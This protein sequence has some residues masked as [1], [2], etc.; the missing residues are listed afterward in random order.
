MPR[1]E[2]RLLGVHEILLKHWKSIVHDEAMI[3]EDRSA[4]CFSIFRQGMI[5]KEMAQLKD[6]G[7]FVF[8]DP[9]QLIARGF[10]VTAN[11]NDVISVLINAEGLNL[12][13][14]LTAVA[15]NG[16]PANVP[17]YEVPAVP[18]KWIDLVTKFVGRIANP[19]TALYMMTLM[20]PQD[21]LPG[22]TRK[23]LRFL[24]RSANKSNTLS[25]PEATGSQT[26]GQSV[27]PAPDDSLGRV[28]DTDATSNPQVSTMN[29]R[30]RS[31]PNYQNLVRRFIRL[32]DKPSSDR[33]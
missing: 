25:L 10:E 4:L 6:K 9:V 18:D 31:D 15:F 21:Q 28:I 29:L 27:P 8:I 24:P 7:I 32:F 5:V 17:G 3:T 30:R 14:I 33:P 23:T 20:V 16:S 11:I 19:A 2:Q 22:A 13:H 12:R 1:Q 26:S